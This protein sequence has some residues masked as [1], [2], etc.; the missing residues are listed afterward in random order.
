MKVLVIGGGGREHSLCWKISQSRKVEEIY[1]AP[2]NGGISQLAFCLNITEISK[3]ADFASQN[4]ID[5]TVVGPEI[6][7]VEGIVDEFEKRG[8]LIFGPSKGAAKIEGSKSFAKRFMERHTIPTG[9]AKIFSKDTFRQAKEYILK[10][11]DLPLVVKASGLAAG[12][13]VIVAKD[14]KTALAALEDCFIEEKFGPAGHKV[15]I[16]EY[17]K[18]EEVSVFVLTDGE[19]ILP[20]P[21]AQDYKRIFDQDKGP[22][23]GGMG[24]YSPAPILSEKL[25][26]EILKTIIEPT[27]KGLKEEGR[28][29]KGV[30][31]GGLILTREG[32]KALEFNCRFG[33][34]ENQAI[35]PLLDKIDLVE[36]MLAVAEGN[37]AHFKDKISWSQDKC[38]C[39]VAASSGYPGPP[40]VGSE[41]RGLREAEK[42]PGVQI[43]QAGTSLKN[44]KIITASGRVL[45]V[46]AK[47]S[48]F[49]EAYRRAYQA[50][51]MIH[52][53]DMHYRK[54]I[55]KR[56]V[57]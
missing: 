45:N 47:G 27:I 25:Y 36:L 54:D 13:G 49:R 4:K 52:F 23:T 24:S 33:D 30:L 46:S 56:V 19:T 50:M 38:I 9:Q 34:P 22:N 18:G 21:S 32:P 12:K 28:E 5:L 53:D 55:G 48:T 57:G 17:L 40:Q 16:E 2:G 1:C 39:V 37:L 6:P 43:F 26:Q 10:N 8:I 42:V 29:Y 31:Y 3:L 11:S 41:I 14:R 15:L 44:G 35:I 51:E 20:L 7:L